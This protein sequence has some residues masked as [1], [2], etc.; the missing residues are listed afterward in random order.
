MSEEQPS[1]DLRRPRQ[2]DC[3]F[4]PSYPGEQT[5][6]CALSDPD[7]VVHGMMGR[8]GKTWPHPVAECFEFN[9]TDRD[10]YVEEHRWESRP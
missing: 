7:R 2:R 9:M 8:C 5:V 3:K 4:E 10:H 6:V 1:R